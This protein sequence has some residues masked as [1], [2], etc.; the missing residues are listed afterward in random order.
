M[1]VLSDRQLILVEELQKLL[2]FGYLKV[3]KGNFDLKR[4]R[5]RKSLL[6]MMTGVVQ[7]YSGSI[8]SLLKNGQT[9]GAEV[10]LRPI[11]ETFINLNYIFIFRSERNALRF[12]FDDEYDRRK[13]G[14]KIKKF[15]ENHSSYKTNF[16]HMETPADWEKYIK[17]RNK[18][19]KKLNTI[20]KRK[21]HE[22]LKELPSLYDRAVAVDKDTLTRTGK[23]KNSLE[24]WYITMY[25]LFSGIT[26]VTPRGMNSFIKKEDNGGYTFITDGK[27]ES[28]ERIAVTTFSLYYQFLRLM[29]KQFKLFPLSEL[30]P[31]KE[32]FRNIKK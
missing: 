8:L 27:L 17:E 15:L 21:Y 9:N 20:N 29:A 3:S 19:L 24:W 5:S 23:L 30:T 26:H 32:F 4:M 10:L 18:A 31:F 25:W 22:E 7:S 12:I 11:V 14:N 13:L 6:F 2:D 1:N 16:D 28:V